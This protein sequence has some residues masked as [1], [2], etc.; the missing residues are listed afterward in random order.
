MEPRKT[1]VLWVSREPAGGNDHG[2]ALEGRV[3]EVDTGLE[4][5]FRSAGQLVAFLEECL[6]KDAA[7]LEESK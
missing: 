3:E 4:R 2:D 6:K 7:R 1:F 5:R